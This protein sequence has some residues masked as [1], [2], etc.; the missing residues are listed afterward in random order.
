MEVK[1][2]DYQHNALDLLLYT[3]STRIGGKTLEDLK[4]ESLAWKLEELG[5]MKDT[6]KSSWEFVR[7]IFE[8]KGVSRAFTHQLVRTRTQSYAQESQR[9]V[10]VSENGFV[11]TGCIPIDQ[12]LSDQM[13]V[14][15]DI[16]GNTSYDTQEVR[17]ILPT[18]VKTNI[19]VGSNLRTLHETALTRLCVRTQGE[20]QDVFMAMKTEVVK[21]HPYFDEFIEVN[22]VQ[23]GLC[24]FPRYADCPV[25]KHVYTVSSSQKNNIKKDWENCN[26]IANPVAKDGRT[27]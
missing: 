1:L 8:I 9:T 10:D 27:M 11:P 18:N 17:A 12:T 19:I 22:C 16:I 7:Y 3:K 2:I 4:N 24:A 21:V 6:I 15:K 23:T 14:Y 25:Q 20:Y 13:S 26:H 5:Y